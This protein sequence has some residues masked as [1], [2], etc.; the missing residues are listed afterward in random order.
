ML[1]EN[2]ALSGNYCMIIVVFNRTSLKGTALMIAYTPYMCAS[3]AS[4][5]HTKSMS[6]S[7]C[8]KY[9]CIRERNVHFF[10]LLKKK[11]LRFS[12]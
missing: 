7:S 9:L 6:A 1:S 3:C 12:K 8:T 4:N 10:F 5:L 2:N 11:I